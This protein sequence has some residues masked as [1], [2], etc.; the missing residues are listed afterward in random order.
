MR[1]FAM[2]RATPLMLF[3]DAAALRD[4]YD[5]AA[6]AIMFSCRCRACYAARAPLLFAPRAMLICCHD[7]MLP[8]YLRYC[9]YADAADDVTPCCFDTPLLPLLCLPLL[10]PRYAASRRRYAFS[11]ARAA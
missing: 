1:C 2:L 10:T 8:P 9:Y 5:A 6:I 7:A 11:P 4:F 3:F